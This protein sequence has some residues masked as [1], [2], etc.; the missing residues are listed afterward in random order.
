VG[1]GRWTTADV[2]RILAAQNR[3]EA[4]PIAP[5]SGLCLMKIFY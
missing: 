2:E 4:G 5:A 1:R 3:T